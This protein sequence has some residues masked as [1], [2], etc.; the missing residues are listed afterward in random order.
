VAAEYT[1]I[2][3]QPLDVAAV[4]GP[5]GGDVGAAVHRCAAQRK[6]GVATSGAPPGPD[7]ISGE[8]LRVELAGPAGLLGLDRERWT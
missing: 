6:T 8:L 5:G 7:R 4:R 2:P 3:P 1:F